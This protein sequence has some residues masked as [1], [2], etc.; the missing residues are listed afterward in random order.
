MYNIIE[1]T[2]TS[3]KGFQASGIACGIKN[4]GNL[5]LALIVS[6][7]PAASAGVF[8]KNIVKGHSLQLTMKHIKCGVTKGILI[9]SGNA[10]AC[11]GPQ[12]YSDALNAATLTAELIKCP[13]EHVL[14]G[15]TG[16]IGVR[17]NN[18]K[19]QSGIHKAVS[20]LSYDGGS[21]AERAIMTT[22][23]LPKE[24]CAVIE[25]NG[26]KITIGGMAK[27]SG[28]I[29][30]N[31]AT[32]IG[33]ITTDANISSQLLSTAL[34]LCV[35]NTFNRVSVDGDTSVCDK[36]VILANGLSGAPEILTETEE[37]TSFCEALYEVCTMLARDIARDG[38]GAT[39]L[40]NVKVNNALSPEDA[41]LTA[42]AVAKSPLVKTAIYGEDANW[43]RIITAAGYSGA[44]FNPENIDIYI[45]DLITCSSGVA[46]DF[47]ED[48]AK[49]ILKENEVTLIIDLKEG[50]YNDHVWTCDF[51]H[52]YIEINGSYRT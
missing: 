26:C 42:I 41:Y 25:I 44:Q 4:N 9:N 18:E 2:I 47:D 51:T 39:K 30:P 23:L 40:I 49:S 12:G 48:K 21:Q 5:D 24:A 29:H 6:D 10:N 31:M 37:Y 11:V 36:V 22:D 13:I 43:G 33:I 35:N 27:G 52:D 17:L 7:V 19:L 16:V 14:F 38:E 15:S 1:G 50:S 34:K 20:A 28:M 8:T 3:P 46:L 45:G 32:M